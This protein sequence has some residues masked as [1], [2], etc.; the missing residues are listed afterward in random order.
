M[1]AVEKVDTSAIMQKAEEA[2][3]KGDTEVLSALIDR[4][5]KRRQ[6]YLGQAQKEAAAAQQAERELA[7]VRG[8]L[9][10]VDP[11]ESRQRYVDM[12]FA[13][14]LHADRARACQ[15]QAEEVANCLP[16]L[17]KQMETILTEQKAIKLVAEAKKVKA[18]LEKTKAKLLPLLR[19]VVEQAAALGREA[20]EF[21]QTSQTAK[22]PQEQFLR[23]DLELSRLLSALDALDVYLA[24]ELEGLVSPSPDGQRR[25][26]LRTPW[27]GHGPGEW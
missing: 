11:A 24:P 6:E 18:E 14:D 3:Q 13:A 27:R 19:E 22:I 16:G 25:V 17:R 9:A 10:Y 23:C 8:Q 15:R 12:H 26:L 20:R 21:N 5:E 1:E 2:T 7:N 4:L